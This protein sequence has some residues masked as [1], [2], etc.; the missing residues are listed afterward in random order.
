MT[1]NNTIGRQVKN[2][3]ICDCNMTIYT[4]YYMGCMNLIFNPIPPLHKYNN[5]LQK[6]LYGNRNFP[7]SINILHVN[8]GNSKFKNKL[9]DIDRIISKYSPD[10]IHIAEANLGS[11]YGN[12]I[13]KYSNYNVEKNLMYND[14]GISISIFFNIVK[15]LRFLLQGWAGGDMHPK[16]SVGCS[17]F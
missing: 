14:I 4:L 13:G 7:K 15:K 6:I 17:C 12:Y 16:L 8:K 1:D 9:C 10:I 11:N 2:C 5:K 3:P